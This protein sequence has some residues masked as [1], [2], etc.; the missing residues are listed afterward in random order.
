MKLFAIYHPRAAVPYLLKLVHTTDDWS[1][2]FSLGGV[3]YFHNIQTNLL[4]LLIQ[5]AGKNPK[6]FG[7]AR[8]HSSY[9]NRWGFKST[10]QQ[11]AAIQAMT[12][13]WA[14]NPSGRKRPG[15]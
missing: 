7:M 6:D 1:G 13:W 5:T 3:T 4:L 10:Q 2:S 8:T 12:I 11:E 15:K 14:K 9:V